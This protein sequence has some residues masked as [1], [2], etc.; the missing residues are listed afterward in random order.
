[1]LEHLKNADEYDEGRAYIKKVGVDGGG[2]VR[3]ISHEVMPSPG[4][5]LRGSHHFF[6]LSSGAIRLR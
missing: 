6:S 2:D 5:R 3:V 4:R 1:M